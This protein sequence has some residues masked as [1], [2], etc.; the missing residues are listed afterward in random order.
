MYK[1]CT[2]QSSSPV[3]YS[4]WRR[5]LFQPL[6]PRLVSADGL[7]FD[8]LLSGKEKTHQRGRGTRRRADGSTSTQEKKARRRSR[9]SKE[10]NNTLF[11]PT[12]RYYAGNPLFLH[13]LERHCLCCPGLCCAAEHRQISCH[14]ISVN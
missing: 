7:S 6:D 2:R 11:K 9:M 14:M 4:F 8:R 3:L 5:G 1:R 12:S 13:A 10:K